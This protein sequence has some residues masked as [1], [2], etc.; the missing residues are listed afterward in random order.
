[1][2]PPKLC[3]VCG[4]DFEWRRKWADCW[5]EVKYCSERCRRNRKSHE[6]DALGKAIL[7]LL[8]TRDS[9]SSICPSEVARSEF[10]ENWRDQMESVRQAGRHLAAKGLIEVTQGGKKVDPK[11]AKGPI[12]YRLP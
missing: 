12:R 9:K 6:G 10:P 8:A 2:K 11:T 5:D 7:S 3:P 1:M 4:R